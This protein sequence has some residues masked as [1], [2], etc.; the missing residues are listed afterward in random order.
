MLRNYRPLFNAV[1]DSNDSRRNANLSIYHT[2]DTQTYFSLHVT[3]KDVLI[4]AD[5]ELDLMTRKHCV[6]IY[7]IIIYWILKDTFSGV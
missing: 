3:V 7:I 6:I 5:H 2:A 4:N 1:G